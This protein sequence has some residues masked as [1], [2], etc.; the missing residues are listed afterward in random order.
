M[1]TKFYLSV[2]A[3]GNGTGTTYDTI[4]AVLSAKLNSVFEEIG[5]NHQHS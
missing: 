4:D 2:D 5:A 3:D 1:N